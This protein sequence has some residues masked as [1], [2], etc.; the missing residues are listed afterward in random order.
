MLYN[1]LLHSCVAGVQNQLAFVIN[2]TSVFLFNHHVFSLNLSV[3]CL[4]QFSL[5]N[6]LESVSK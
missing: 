5:F 1:A 6:R 3:D 2:L 4:N